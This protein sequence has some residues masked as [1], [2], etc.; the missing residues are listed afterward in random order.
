MPVLHNRVS[1]AELKK[2]ML[3]E[4]R[5]RLTVSFYRYFPIADPQ[6]FRDDLYKKLVAIDVFGRI[7]VAAEG[8]NAQ[9]SVPEEK[10]ESL[11]A[12]LEATPGLENLRL[13]I[14]VEQGP[15][16]WVLKIKVRDN[17]VADGITD[18]SFSMQQTGAYVDAEAFNK[19]TDN[20]DTVVVDMRNHY[21]Y[22][23]GHFDG[24][25]EVPSDT[26]RE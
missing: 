21:E 3:A 2:K 14:A 8:I 23:V 26:F 7:Y 9:V 10:L 6:F 18:S 20:P 24:A 16:F 1:A 5:P 11:R 13:N 15:A 19:L 22:E 12:M 17:I 25:I 4:N